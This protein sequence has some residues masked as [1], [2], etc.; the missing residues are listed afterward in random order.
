M[1]MAVA[2][3]A[4]SGHNGYDFVKELGRLLDTNV[5]AV[6]EVFALY[7]REAKPQ[8]DYKDKLKELIQALARHGLRAD[9][10]SYADQLRD[11]PGM[12]DLY[13]DLTRPDQTGAQ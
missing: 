3:F 5:E 7:L 9:A 6:N 12:R 13:L 4:E 8:F 2:P 10:I 11:L 1:L